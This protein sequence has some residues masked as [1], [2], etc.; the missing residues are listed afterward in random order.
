MASIER[1]GSSYRITVSAGY[2][3]Y[4]NQIRK[5]ETWTPPAGM[6]VS[7]AD[8]EARHVAAILRNRCAP[9]NMPRVATPN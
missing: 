1:R 2:D 4:G 9:G 6:S 7:K 3:I 5:R 8:K